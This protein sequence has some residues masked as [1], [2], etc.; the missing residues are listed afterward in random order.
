MRITALLREAWASARAAKIPSLLCLL[1]V[2]A[3]CVAAILT[4][5][6]SASAA[7]NMSERMTQAGARRLVVIDG[8]ASGINTPAAL[9]QI[10]TLQTVTGAN[11]LGT[12]LDVVNA[13]IGAGGPEFP[14][15]TVEGDLSNVGELVRGREP[16]P[17]EALVST[18][19]LTELGLAEPVGAI[20]TPN[21]WQRFPIVGAFR[22]TATFADLG[23]GLLIVPTEEV[24]GRELRVT[25]TDITAAR[26]TVAAVLRILNPQSTQSLQID[27]PTSLADTAADLNAQLA[28]YG[29]SLLAL[30]LGAGGLLVA[31]VVL[32]DVLVRRRDLGRRR[33]LGAT[34][35]D[36]AALVMTRAAM[37]AA[38]G[39]ALGC[40]VAWLI[41]RF[42]GAH[43]STPLDF[44]L[45]VGVL[46]LVTAVVASVAPAVFAA[47]RD[48][49]SVM[50][51]P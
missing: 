27:S 7:A 20:A 10:Q 33:T 31:A 38:S 18:E 22:P 8:L 26:A 40:T 4:V 34:R 25:I 24:P 15:W 41:N 17:G 50:R 35:A 32:T 23:A 49:I 3:M 42:T 43:I 46:G 45:A 51:T 30:I 6:Q 36:L 48:P 2:A 19:I 11:I 21:G 37:I 14:A 47:R 5:G 12:P 13:D 44:T 39:A 1:V 16:Q 28:S 29:R 9:A